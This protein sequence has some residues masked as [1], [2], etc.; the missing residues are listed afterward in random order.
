[1]RL[2]WFLR[3]FALDGRRAERAQVPRRANV[4]NALSDTYEKRCV[5][6]FLCYLALLKRAPKAGLF[7]PSYERVRRERLITVSNTARCAE[8]PATHGSCAASSVLCTRHTPEYG[9]TLPA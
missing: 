8:Q 1:M 6:A 9:T 7:C 4:D 5:S 2:N 3:A